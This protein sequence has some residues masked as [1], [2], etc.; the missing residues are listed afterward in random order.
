M[1]LPHRTKDEFAGGRAPSAVNVPVVNF[2][3]GGMVPNAAF[4]EEVKKAFPDKA[5]PIIV[6]G[7]ARFGMHNPCKMCV[8]K[9]PGKHSIAAI[10]PVVTNGSDGAN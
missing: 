8:T 7:S 4:L 6:V 5:E 10:E 2:G 9:Q 1:L 3:A